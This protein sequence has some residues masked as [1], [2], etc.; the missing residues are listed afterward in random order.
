MQTKKI[1]AIGDIHIFRSKRFDEHQNLFNKFYKVIDEEKPDLVVIPGDVIDS[2][3]NI[4]PEQVIL[5]QDLLINI[6]N[7][8]PVIQILGNHDLNLQNIER[9]DLI[10]A[11][12][13]SL[14]GQ[15]KNPI[16][17]YPHSG[18][19][20][21]YGINWAVWSCLDNQLNPYTIENIETNPSGEN[22]TIGL[23]HG[24]VGGC[25]S[26]TGMELKDGIDITE[27]ENC[28]ICILSD[29]HK[30]Q[31]FRNN[32]INYTG[33]FIQV[34][35]NEVPHGTYLVYEWN[36]ELNKHFPT[37]KNID[38]EFSTLVYEITDINELPEFEKIY[39]DQTIKLAYNQDVISKADV[40]EYKKKLQ[41]IYN[42][43]I[44]YK[45]IVPQRKKL[46]TDSITIEGNGEELIKSFKTLLKDYLES[47]KSNIKFLKDINEDYQ[48]ILDIDK[49][50]GG[51]LSADKTFEAGDFY[52]EK[53]IINNLFSFGPEDTEIDI[54]SVDGINGI[55]G[56]NRAGKSKIFASL[57]FALYGSMPKSI[58]SSK[59]VI[60]KDN[61]DK[62]A[63]VKVIAVKNG[64]RY[65]VKRTIE[66]VSPKNEKVSYVLEFDEIDENNNSIQNLRD[67]KRQETEKII[68]RYFGTEETFELLSMFSAQKKQ[69]EFIDCSN[70]L[71]LEYINKFM[72]LQEFELKHK[73]AS[74]E[75]K[76]QNKVYQELIKDFNDKLNIEDLEN[77]IEERRNRIIGIENSNKDLDKALAG[78]DEEL[79]ILNYEYQKHKIIAETKYDDV[80][81]I[82]YKIEQQNKKIADINASRDNKHLEIK[83]IEDKKTHLDLKIESKKDLIKENLQR[84]EDLKI[85]GKQ[86]KIEFQTAVNSDEEKEVLFD[87]VDMY[88]KDIMNFN[89]EVAIL[90]SEISAKEKQLRIDICNNCGK[91]FSEKDKDNTRKQ[92]KINQ[93]KVIS[94]NTKINDLMEKESHLK[95]LS[96]KCKDVINDI[97]KV[98]SENKSLEI[99]ISK[100]ETEKSNF[101]FEIQKIENKYLSIDNEVAKIQM[102][103]I[104]LEKQI[105]ETNRIVKSIKEASE[106]MEA[107]RITKLPLENEKQIYKKQIDDNNILLGEF[108][109]KI[110]QLI[111]EVDD[112]KKKYDVI[113][114]KEEEIRLLSLYRE[115]IAKDGLPLFILKQRIGAINNEINTIIN[116]IFDFDLRFT[117]NEETGELKIE[118][119]YDEDKDKSDVSLAS[120]SETFIINLCIRVG[121]SQI[122]EIPKCLSLNVDEGFGT[123]DS[124]NIDKIPLLFSTL[125][126]YYKNIILVS[127][128][129]VMKEIYTCQINVT[130]DKYTKIS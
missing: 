72:G 64:K 70:S 21:A 100:F 4:S 88:K 22:Y 14:Q 1:L 18:I 33:N 74:E 52:F 51:D 17:F 78:L 29:I 57:M 120:G 30:R 75:F 56:E 80:D 9:K 94:I 34:K 68:S 69:I 47:Q 84:I 66:P 95:Q 77:E 97:N 3:V 71:R 83:V 58:S 16:H 6:T 85:V 109:Q 111:K 41:K 98:I 116:Q 130:K 93:D 90:E 28:D 110:K 124:K 101:D 99:E 59:N 118:F 86:Y 36:E 89:K 81:F 20:A 12:V 31:S 39:E 91:E 92:I 43:K 87:L 121:L 10:S 61:R 48:L 5:L 115:V 113:K 11:V 102:G 67:E 53:V 7:K 50:F 107:I 24:A 128:L 73:E 26:D 55:N 37:V 129:D 108:R 49:I 35:E 60:N 8:V 32:E 65:C 112:Y 13:G 38:N 15:T 62:P 127:H 106:K 79:S 45:P 42:N 63:Y 19:Y 125:L 117:V 44:D 23:F 82:N 122:S 76:T 114:D 103:I 105:D 104:D 96:K 119:I 123:L 27:F 46:N 25:L 54:F 126:N 2:K 40:L